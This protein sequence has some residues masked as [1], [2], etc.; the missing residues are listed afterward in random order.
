M[1]QTADFIGAPLI[2][3]GGLFAVHRGKAGAKHLLL[4]VLPR[5]AVGGDFPVFLGNESIDFVFTVDHHAR[6]DAL[7]PAGGQP[8]FHFGPEQRADFIT[9]QPVESTAGLLGVDAAHIQLS[10][11]FDRVLDGLLRDLVELNAAG[12]VFINTEDMVQMP[13]DGLSLAV[14][15]CCE[16]NLGSVAGFL[17]DA[18][19]DVAAAAD[20]D[21]F[22]F[23]V[24]IRIDAE[25]TFR[26][27]ANMALGGLDLIAF[28]QI[29]ADGFCLGRRLDDNEFLFCGCHLVQYSF[30][31]DHFRTS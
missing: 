2:G 15:V 5:A 21:I 14:R 22:H 7:H 29:A 17:A 11:M 13:A 28:A 27:V 31:R 16:V 6:G 30:L 9:H 12:L 3:N 1:D 26:E 4:L 18:A 20:R 25:L 23:K 8:F 24:F 10:G 19:E